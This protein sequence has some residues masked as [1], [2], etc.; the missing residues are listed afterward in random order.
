MK[1]NLKL[2]LLFL[3]I[4]LCLSAQL[5][6]NS[7]I[8]IEQLVEDVLVG[9]GVEVSNISYTGTI[10]N[11]GTFNSLNSNVGIGEGI[12]LSTGNIGDAVGPNDDPGE[13]GGMG[14]PGDQDLEQLLGLGVTTFD[15]VVLEFDF[16][17]I[18][19]SIVFNYVFASEEYLEY[20]NGGYFDVFGFFL[21]GPGINGPFQ[22]NA[23][24][25][26]TI[27]GTNTA[28]T[29][30]NINDNVNS[31]YYVDNG[32]GDS[33][34][35]NSDNTIVQFDGLTTRLTAVLQVQACETYHIKLAIA[36]VG[37]DVFDSGVFLEKGSFSL[38]QPIANAGPDRNICSGQSTPIGFFPIQD[39]TYNWSP[40]L[41]LNNDEIANPVLTLDNNG[42]VVYQQVYELSVI[43]E[44]CT[45][46][47]DTYI[48]Q[49][50]ATVYPE[51]IYEVFDTVMCAEDTV[52]IRGD[53]QANQVYQ[54]TGSEFLIETD[55]A[56]PFL[57][58]ENQEDEII[59]EQLTVTYIDTLSGCV[60]QSNM[61]YSIYPSPDFSMDSLWY[62][63]PGSDVQVLVEGLDSFVWSP[64]NF[65]D[66]INIADPTLSPPITQYYYLQGFD[67]LGCVVYDSLEVIVEGEIP[68]E[69]GDSII[70]C[71][72]DSI[73][74]GGDPTSPNGVAYL[75][76]NS[77]F[78]DNDTVSNPLVFPDADQYMFVE[79]STDTCT[80]RDSVWVT[81]RDLPNVEIFGDSIICQG[82]S[83][84]LYASGADSLM[85]A[86]EGSWFFLNSDSLIT[87]TE[88]TLSFV[89]M[90]VDSFM[91]ESFD[92][93]EVITVAL[94]EVIMSPDTSIC[95]GDTALLSS[96]G[97]GDP[98]WFIDSDT[99]R[100][101]S[102]FVNPNI[103]TTYLLERQDTNGC[104]SNDSIEVL[105]NSLP[106]IE[107]TADT[108]VCHGTPL[109]LWATGGA[110]YEWSRSDSLYS[111]DS[112]VVLYPKS[113]SRYILGVIDSNLCFNQDSVDVVMMTE[114]V[115]GL[116]Y[117][118]IAR[119]EG[120][121]IDLSSQSLDAT[122]NTW[123]VDGVD[124]SSSDEAQEVLE[125]GESHLIQLVA[126]NG[127]CLDTISFNF[128]PNTTDENFEI[129]YTE[130]LTLNNDGQN[131]ELV[132][133]LTND[134]DECTSTKVYTRWGMKVYDSEDH[135]WNWYGLNEYNAQPV[136][137][138][139]YF[140][141]I[142]VR[143][144]IIFKGYLTV[145][146]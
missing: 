77:M 49:M 95:I 131:D 128:N 146:R 88:D 106:D 144:E 90:G 91:C 7:N 137:E 121:I 20:V 57:T 13:S 39:Q 54:W 21:S 26:A 76:S 16:V 34:P 50:V 127:V 89:A 143:E 112:S 4:N 31:Q 68:T 58:G 10:S 15:A 42:D 3:F 104:V 102:V 22:N 66:D 101:D 5:T 109:Y 8:S 108:A 63:C 12:I 126:E 41:G 145:F 96:T 25:V 132:V 114:P 129:E 1:T 115:A 125:Y 9:E 116:D 19:D 60:G 17:P 85:W 97:E 105:V 124:V 61:T 51:P 81:V 94:P 36:D 98:F 134:F 56:E 47:N 33:W 75:W 138:G 53:V 23:T 40:P 37:D 27:P 86:Y 30:D 141:V 38:T 117:S 110:S 14:I 74:A 122:S 73:M 87:I 24:N 44:G 71:L 46:F 107:L 69:A 93:I 78:V 84:R 99:I 135:P 130:V 6:V 70:I 72:N 52:Q 45:G 113:N 111:T 79:T 11:R 59:T 55:V 28:V 139:T 133:Q 29:I 83:A 123:M 43:K 18:E 82:D 80:G 119:C 2:S 67:S 142:T 64:N 136:S 103:S 32:T 100:F 65:I 48:D 62:V 92:T 35:E 120:A 118:W 140:F